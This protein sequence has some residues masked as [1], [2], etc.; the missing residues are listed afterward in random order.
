MI[1]YDC[2]T[3]PNPRR[4]RMLIAEKGLEVERRE[5]S[6]LKGEQ[7]SPAFLAINPRATIPVLVTETG[8]ALTETVAIAAYLEELHPEPPLLGATREAR[9]KALMWNAIVETQGAQ[10]IGEAFRNTHPAMKGRALP[11][12]LDLD[13]IPALAERSFKRVDAFFALLEERLAQSP[14][15]AGEAFTL[16]DISA[17]A[18]VEFARVIRRR[19]P[20]DNAKSRAWLEAIRARPSAAL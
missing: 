13:Q 7:L 17:F 6:M 1:F 8:T 11:G 19:I 18:F 3:A 20:E 12:P 9:A 5:V 4:A 2:A 14:Y 10:P 15:L 16:A